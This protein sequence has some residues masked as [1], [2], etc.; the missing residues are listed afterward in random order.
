M[1]T[2]QLSTIGGVFPGKDPL[3]LTETPL[4]PEGHNRRPHQ[5]AI[6]KGHFQPEGHNR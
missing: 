4:Q 1:H 6:T 3:P 5:K 2:V